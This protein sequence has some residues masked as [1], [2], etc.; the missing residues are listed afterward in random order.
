MIEPRPTFREASR[1]VATIVV[2]VF[3]AAAMAGEITLYSE[4]DFGGAAM[5]VRG[6]APTLDRIGFNDTASSIVVRDGVWEVCTDAQFRGRCAQLQPGEYS[7]FGVTQSERI[8]SARQIAPST[9]ARVI[10]TASAPAVAAATPGPTDVGAPRIVLYENTGFAGRAV[11]LSSTVLNLDSV[12]FGDR[13]DSAIVQGGIWRLCDTVQSRGECVELGPGRYDS[14]GTLTN[15]INSVEVVAAGQPTA[16]PRGSGRVVFYQYPN[17]RGRATI[18]EGP[19]MPR[20]TAAY[21]DGIAGSMR[22]ERGHWMFCSDAYYAGE[23]RTF[24]PGDYA[25]LPST[26]EHVASGRQLPERY[27]LSLR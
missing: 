27:S 2:S 24:G 22:V 7:S 12:R 15:R 9:P 3:S 18:V 17:F 23:C 26:L 19:D 21:F 1:A 4:R 11:E 10:D 8:A 25:R 20:L 5:T 6:P 13:A 14:L 16:V